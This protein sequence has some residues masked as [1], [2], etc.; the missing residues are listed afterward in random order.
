MK[1]IWEVFSIENNNNTFQKVDLNLY[2]QHNTC[3]GKF[4]WARQPKTA[5]VILVCLVQRR[6]IKILFNPYLKNNFANV[7]SCCYH[8]TACNL[9]RA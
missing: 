5:G 1:D 7:Y 8:K 6:A 2:M 9:T 4:N 3:D